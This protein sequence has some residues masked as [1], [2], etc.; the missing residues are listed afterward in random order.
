MRVSSNIPG[1]RTFIA[2]ALLSASLLVAPLLTQGT[3]AAISYC[4]TDPV[5]SLSNG[6]VVTMYADTYDV[7]S[8]IKSVSY[9]LHGPVGTTVTGVTYDQYGYLEHFQYY[10]DESSGLYQTG[11]VVTSGNSS[12]GVTVNAGVANLVCNQPP[13]AK[14]GW[15]T[16]YLAINFHCL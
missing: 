3:H 7:L 14:R 2:A 6:A 9:V 15:A 11:T 10:A 13:R 1:R 16:N 4:R 5:V 12:A 8:D